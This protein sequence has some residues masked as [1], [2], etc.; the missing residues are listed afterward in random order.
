MRNYFLAAAMVAIAVPAAAQNV[1]TPAYV[2]AWEQDGVD[3]GTFSFETSVDSG[4]AAPVL[5]VTCTGTPNATCR[6]A[7]PQSMTT[8]L[9]TIALRA[10]RTLDGVRYNSP[11]TP[12]VTINYLANPAPGVPRNFGPILPPGAQ[13]FV[14]E[15]TVRGR[16]HAF[17]MEVAETQLDLGV[18]LYYGSPYG[19]TLGAYSVIPG[20]RYMTAFWRPVNP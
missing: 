18:P 8:G 16:Y 3:I 14:V 5:G 19:F 9:H 7:L 17:G 4:A 15:G 10:V 2:L 6:G 1:V 12:P 20:D 11:Y 13:G